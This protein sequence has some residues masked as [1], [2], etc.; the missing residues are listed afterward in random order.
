MSRPF[1]RQTFR[2]AYHRWIVEG[3]FNEEPWYYP[4]YRSRYE[5]I[6]KRFAKLADPQPG[7][8]LDIGGGQHA[9]L[10]MK[11]WGDQA[12]VADVVEDHLGYVRDQGVKTVRWDLSREDPPFGEGETFDYVIFSEVIEHL[13]I[14]GSVALARLRRCL[15]PGGLMLCTTPNF[16]RMRNVVY[17]ATGRRIYDHFRLPGS[18]PQGHVIEYDEPRL[19]WQFERAGF[20]DVV[21]DKQNYPHNPTK[22]I[23]QVMYWMGY[24]LNQLPRFRESL[25]A[26]AYA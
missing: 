3:R 4:R 23:H 15:R 9:L 16:Y 17:V 25:V 14:P 5:A 26:T 18:G 10:A 21:I 1:D 19:R 7:R 24:P 11:L 12:T 6:L 8:L 2:Q 13:P 22:P 20:R